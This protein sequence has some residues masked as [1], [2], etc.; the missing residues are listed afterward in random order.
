MRL[1]YRP[2]PWTSSRS[3]PRRT[4]PTR[5]S[6]STPPVAPVRRPRRSPS[7]RPTANRLAHALRRLGA[8]RGDRV[9]WCGPELARGDHR[10]STRRAR[11]ASTSV[12]VSYRFNA[13]EMQYVI[14]NSD[15]TVVVVDAEQAPLVA[16]V[17]DQLPKVRAVARVRRRRAGRVRRTGT[18]SSRR[19]TPTPPEV[20]RRPGR[21]HRGRHDDLHVGHHRE[22][23]GRDAHRHR[24]RASAR[25]SRSCTCS[26]S[27]SVHLTTGPLYHS[28]PLSFALVRARARRHR[29]SCCASSTRARGCGW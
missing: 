5:P 16:S 20:A 18:T 3:T 9:V 23:E 25:C 7:S 15:A 11:R 10:R 19:R 21:R 17:R 8:R 24:R 2:A 26:T 1:G 12:P 14:D 13:D 29:S 28:G 27:P 6:S 22:A 4:A